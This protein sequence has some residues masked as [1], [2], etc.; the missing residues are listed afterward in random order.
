M[1]CDTFVA[2]A[3][4]TRAGATLFGKNSD[5]PPR[6]CQ[7][8]VQ[9]PR[10]RQP[11][12]AALRCQ[13]LEIPDV[14]ETAAL[15]GS[16]P[17]WLWGLEHGVNEHR[18]AIGNETVYSKEPLGAVG[19]T[20]MDLV[21]LG[22]ERGRTAAEALDVMTT[23]LERHGQGGSGH[24]HLEW[25][26]HNAFLIVDPTSA[27][28]LETSGPHWVAAPVAEHANISNGL[29]IGTQWTRGHRDVTRFAVEQGWWGAGAGPVDFARAYNDDGTVP[30]N[31]CAERRR[32]GTALLVEARGQATAESFR[33]LLRDHYDAGV[34][35]RPRDVADPFYF[36]ICMHADP[37][38]N[39]TASMVM[40]LP[41]DPKALVRGWVSLGSPCIGAFLP[42]YP[43]AT[44]PSRLARGGADPDPG[45]PWWE[46][47][48]LLTLVERDSPRFGPIVRARWDAFE[49]ELVA[50]ASVVEATAV[51]AGDPA[52]PL[53]AFMERAVDRYL[54]HARRLRGELEQGA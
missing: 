27:W 20:G 35:N 36:S 16:Q 29:A 7:R 52:R 34:V 38:D 25:P 31:V 48:E 24:V 5:R 51:H 8:I 53:T 13:Y 39:T 4:A 6:E 47:R 32:R 9:M 42:C 33:R 37:L 18:V 40:E 23:L 49:A 45:S 21:R 11:A 54:D 14:V 17:Y 3:T 41:V 28:I 43:Q 46:M 2:L 1:G 12:G 19:L 15:V 26:Y 50:E 30:P 22:L 44:I 10:R